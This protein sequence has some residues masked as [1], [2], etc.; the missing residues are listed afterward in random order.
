MGL[1]REMVVKHLG[2][3]VRT[4]LNEEGGGQGCGQSLWVLI[5]LG[6]GGVRPYPEAGQG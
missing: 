5:S 2:P 3:V 1:L 6:W 4:E